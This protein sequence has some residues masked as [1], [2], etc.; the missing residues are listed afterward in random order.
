MVRSVRGL[1]Q[2]AKDEDVMERAASI[3]CTALGYGTCAM[4][5]REDD[6]NFRYHAYFVDGVDEKHRANDLTLSASAYW[7]LCQ[8]AVVVEGAMW[9]PAEHPER[10]LPE[11]RS[12]LVPELALSAA[13][14]SNEGPLLWAPMV[15]DDGNHF[16]FVSPQVPSLSGPP[17]PLDALL[18]ATLAELA[19][20]SLEVGRVDAAGRRSAAVARAQRR[21][22]EDMIAASLEV[23]GQAALDDAL[24]DIARAMA[25]A[26][27]FRRAAI[28]LLE[29]GAEGGG[30]RTGVGFAPA[31]DARLGGVAVS[32]AA[33]VGL[34]QAEAERLNGC[35]TTLADFAPMMRPEMRVS[36][37]Y[38]FD[39]RFFDLPSEFREKLSI[40]PG[41]AGCVEGMWHLEDSLTVP[42]EDRQG[43][44][45]GIISLD[46]PLNGALPTR[47]DCRALELFADQCALA[48][49]ESRRLEAALE[50]AT[51]DDLTG[52]A[53]RRALME[54]APELVRS[55][56][57]DGSTCSALYFDID[58]FKD[59]NDSFGHATG[60][61]VIGAVGRAIANR[62]RRGDLVARYGGEE[63]VAVLPKTGVEE[64]VALA[65]EIRRLV[66]TATLVDVYPPLQLHVSVGVA[67]LRPGDDTQALLAAADA[68]LY[69]AKRAGRDRVCVAPR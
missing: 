19:A 32:L 51:T 64:A 69:Q 39:H 58:H 43:Y 1:G 59:I 8:A 17:G 38:L 33:T 5:L 62:L 11:V 28:Y 4:A 41:V 15:A 22:L 42:L 57:R 20:L 61:E 44:L 14:S 48:V 47:E 7:A 53:N 49:A 9:V 40:A 46:E 65:E 30:F 25:T 55:A 52:L 12:G 37:S 10:S 24:A 63:F 18:L 16:G 68:A 54:R 27:G 66:A 36:R 13:G 67:G 26:V 45:A 21:Q 56:T 34:D 50:D 35:F 60:D 2:A 6:G 3:G 29:P 31:Q 23:R